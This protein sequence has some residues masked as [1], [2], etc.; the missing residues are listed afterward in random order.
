[1]GTIM[2]SVGTLVTSLEDI[3]PVLKRTA[4]VKAATLG[5][6]CLA[7][8]LIG[9]LFCTQAGSYW[10]EIF[11]FYSANHGILICGIFQCVTIGWIYGMKRFRFDVSSM[12]P[13]E[14]TTRLL[15]SNTA[16]YLWTACWKVIT[17]VL[18]SVSLYIFKFI[19]FNIIYYV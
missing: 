2:A 11:D 7:Y 8:F 6:I 3:F 18:L 14:S 4:L 9:L 12:I 1:M 16:I 13:I 10:I 15:L 19:S 17:P 5:A